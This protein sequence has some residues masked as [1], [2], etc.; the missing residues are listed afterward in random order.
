MASFGFASCLAKNDNPGDA[1]DQSR[2]FNAYLEVFGSTDAG[3]KKLP[4]N[5]LSF[6]T[7]PL[8]LCPWHEKLVLTGDR[9]IVDTVNGW[10]KRV[11]EG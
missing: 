6:S 4:G 2:R 9:W 7:L 3:V 10:K 5:N 11:I 8:P 1:S